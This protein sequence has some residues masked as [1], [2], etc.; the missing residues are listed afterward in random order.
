[1]MKIETGPCLNILECFLLSK[2]TIFSTFAGFINTDNLKKKKLSVLRDALNEVVIPPVREIMSKEMPKHYKQMADRYKLHRQTFAKHVKELRGVKL[3]YKSI[4]NNQYIKNPDHYDY[5]V[6]DAISLAK[7]FLEPHMAKFTKFDLRF[8]PAAVLWVLQCV[9]E[10]GKN[11]NGAAN[12]VRITVPKPC[13][14][15]KF[16]EMTDDNYKKGFRAMESLV[17]SFLQSEDQKEILD[18]LKERKTQG[19]S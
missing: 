14:H 17:E 8:D 9:E 18:K 4:N 5:N 2:Y 12:D 7:I 13:A 3:N 11:I 6:K 10:F 19:K 16:Y 1:M 15:Y